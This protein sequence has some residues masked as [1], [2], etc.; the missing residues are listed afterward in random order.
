[1]QDRVVAAR[2]PVTYG[3]ELS[4]NGAHIDLYCFILIISLMCNVA[5][6]ESVIHIKN[7]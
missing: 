2:A 6:N 4:L 5:I 1:M 7:I 3:C